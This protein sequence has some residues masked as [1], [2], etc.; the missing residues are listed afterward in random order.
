MTDLAKKLN[1]TERIN[2]FK[3]LVDARKNSLSFRDAYITMVNNPDHVAHFLDNALHNASTNTG[4][5]YTEERM[6]SLLV[7][8]R[9]V[10]KKKYPGKAA[11]AK[12]NKRKG[13]AP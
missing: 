8:A 7:E 13:H 10:F 12:E 3:N 4:E 5:Y 11:Y 6:I 9:A 1:K 2:M